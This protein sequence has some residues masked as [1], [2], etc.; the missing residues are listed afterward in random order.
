MIGNHYFVHK[1]FM[2]KYV[3]KYYLICF[4]ERFLMG[5][6]EKVNYMLTVTMNM[7]I[8]I[9]IRIPL[10]AFVYVLIIDKIN[11]TSKTGSI[12]MYLVLFI[13][14]VVTFFVYHPIR[15]REK[16]DMF[17]YAPQSKLVDEIDRIELFSIPELG[18]EYDVL[19]MVES[20]DRD[21]EKARV[22]LQHQ[23]LKLGANAVLNVRTYVDNNVSGRVDTVLGM[24][25]MPYGRSSTVTTYH[26]EGT[27]IWIK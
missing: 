13:V 10:V 7:L 4:I 17:N 12:I 23:A 2:I 25:R 20:R 24:P 6:I 1:T 15:R 27:A 11:V 5:I 3:N 14:V 8:T 9:F 19:G 21:Q 16:I 26:Y 18:R 22:K